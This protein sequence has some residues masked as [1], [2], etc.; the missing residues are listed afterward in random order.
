MIVA[1]ADG[2]VKMSTPDAVQTGLETVPGVTILANNAVCQLD[3]ISGPQ[4]APVGSIGWVDTNEPNS[5]ELN[6]RIPG[7]PGPAEA[8]AI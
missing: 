8:S 3:A 6:V 4:T 7:V 2:R 5:A 1:A